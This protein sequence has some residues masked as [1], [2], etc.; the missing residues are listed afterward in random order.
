MLNLAARV[1]LRSAGE[2]EPN[3]MVGCVIARQIQGDT[4][5]LGVG[6]HRRFGGPHAEIEA[7]NICQRM[8]RDTTGATAWVT[9]EPCAHEG[10][11]PPCA[12]AL[13]EAEI[14]E[15]VIARRDP[16]A[17]ASGGADRLRENGVSVRRTEASVAAIR[18]SDP[19]VKRHTT[20]LPWIIVKW[21][22]TID[23]KIATRTGASKWISNERSRLDAHRLRSR[24]DAIVTGIGTV[25]ADDPML[26][27][28]NIR[29]QRR[30]AARIV[31][32][33]KLELPPTS[34]LARSAE[35]A[36]VVVWCSED[37]VNERSSRVSKLTAM[38]V[39]VETQPVVDGR[40]DLSVCFADLAANQGATNVLVEAGPG[41]VSD[42]SRRDLIDEMRVHIAPMAL[43]DESALPALRGSAIE[44]LSE[45]QRYGLTKM[46]RFGDDALLIYRR[47]IV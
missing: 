23:G 39:A 16:H 10:K 17:E 47:P 26:T 37:S 2:V 12:D 25:R 15:V 21:A 33:P 32:D 7:L 31:V 24:V 30:V 38:G 46:R 40:L 3:P 36:P 27:A 14:A 18:L 4:Q 20:G 45:A 13:I 34:A 41:L 9:L 8:G 28:R 42:L 43:A 35:A 1:A 11:T 5:I 22:Q 29:R 6:H 44:S 19:F